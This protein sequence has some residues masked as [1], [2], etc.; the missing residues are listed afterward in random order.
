MRMMNHY[1]KGINVFPGFFPLLLDF[2]GCALGY[3]CSSSL[4]ILLLSDLS[5]RGFRLLSNQWWFIYLSCFRILMSP[6]ILLM[7]TRSAFNGRC[8]DKV[9]GCKQE[10][11]DTYFLIFIIWN[12]CSISLLCAFVTAKHISHCQRR[13]SDQ[14]EIPLLLWS[15]FQ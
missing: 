12:T 9:E 15:R 2:L 6:R 14:G 8:F 11:R 4:T 10:K 5:L 7:T 3:G 1:Y 13:H